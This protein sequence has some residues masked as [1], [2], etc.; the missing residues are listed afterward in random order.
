MPL[1]YRLPGNY[2]TWNVIVSHKFS[3]LQN[4]GQL[5]QLNI[6]NFVTKKV[7]GDPISTCNVNEAPE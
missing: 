2:S 1:N 3:P 5:M 6:S 4:P 7:S